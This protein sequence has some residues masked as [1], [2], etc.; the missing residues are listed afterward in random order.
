MKRTRLLLAASVLAV[1]ASP[2]F[3]GPLPGA[4]FTTVA[5]GSR[6]NAN[7]YAAKEDVYLDGGPGPNAP[8]S[9]AALPAGDYYF[10]VT[11]PSGKVLLSQDAVEKRRFTVSAAGVITSA[12]DHVTGVDGDHAAL[13]AKTVRLMPYADTPN[14]GGVYKVWVTPIAQFVGNVTKIDNPTGYHGFIPSWSKMDTYKVRRKTTTCTPS[15]LT[16][17]KFEDNNSNGVWD[18]GEGEIYGWQMTVIDPSGASNEYLTPC[19]LDTPIAGTWKVIENT[20]DSN[21]TVA[22]LDGQIASMTPLAVPTVCVPVRK[23]CGEA[24]TVIYGNN[25]C[26]CH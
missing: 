19:T 14:N 8:A 12:Y 21:Q 1:A 11:D 17:R 3:A 9:A 6:V 5:D 20:N 23:D 4:I 24:H 18:V 25:F 15:T 7:L 26:T 16:L 10:Q 22:V 2:S 13:G